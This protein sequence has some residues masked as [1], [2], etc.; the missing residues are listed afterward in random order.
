MLKVRSCQTEVRNYSKLKHIKMLQSRAGISVQRRR[1][2]REVS[3]SPAR[4][5]EPRAPWFP[6]PTEQPESS[7][8]FPGGG[9]AEPPF[10]SPPLAGAPPSPAGS[11]PAPSAG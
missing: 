6:R 11:P 3:A 9:G 8:E 4:S 1:R 10:A 5:R 2:K 7:S